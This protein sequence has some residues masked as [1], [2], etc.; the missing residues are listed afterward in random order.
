[1]SKLNNALLHLSGNGFTKV[2]IEQIKSSPTLA[3]MLETFTKN[4]NE[5][6]VFGDNG[7]HFNTK[8]GK[9]TIGKP[10]V[11]TLAH[12]LG[13]ALGKLQP[14]NLPEAKSAKE[15]LEIKLTA[16]GEAKCYE[17]I[18]M[19]EI[20]SNGN[21][22][23]I[24]PAEKAAGWF[25]DKL[26]I[27]Q[28]DVHKNIAD[29][30]KNVK[31][32]ND[33]TEE[34][35]K[36][37]GKEVKQGIFSGQT[38]DYQHIIPTF[39]YE[40]EY[41]LNF[42]LGQNKY[43]HANTTLRPDYKEVIGSEIFDSGF[44]IKSLTNGRNGQLGTAG[45]DV[46]TNGNAD[47]TVLAK[48]LENYADRNGDLWFGDKGNDTIQG[49]SGKDI[50]LGGED[51]DHLY[52]NGGNDILGGNAGDD[53]LYGGEGRN[54]LK[55]GVGND[56][57]HVSG[58]DTIFDKDF[59]GSIHFGDTDLATQSFKMIAP[60]L[61]KSEDG[62]FILNSLN[63]AN[64]DLLII[65]S[66]TNSSALVEGFFDKVTH[67]D[68]SYQ[69]L[70][71]T[72]ADKISDDAAIFL[73]AD[74]RYNDITVLSS[75][76]VQ[77]GSK[78]DFVEAEQSQMTAYLGRG[79][80]RAHGGR[81]AD[82]IAGQEGNDVIFGGGFADNDVK[83][84]D[85][86][87]GGSGRDIIYGLHGNDVI[88]ASDAENFANTQSI[89]KGGD[90]VGGGKGNDYL[91]GSNAKDVLM[92]GEG[93]DTI[94]GGAGSDVIVGDGDVRLAVEIGR[95]T[96]SGSSSIDVNHV[97]ADD[98]LKNFIQA[99][100]RD[101]VDAVIEYMEVDYTYPGRG[102]VAHFD[103]SGDDAIA[104]VPPKIKLTHYTHFN[105]QAAI[106]VTTGDYS[107]DAP[108]GKVGSHL[109]DNGADD[110]LYGGR[111]DDLIIGQSGNDYLEGGIGNDILWGDDNR[112]ASV[113]GND[114]LKGGEGN[115]TFYGG[116][117]GDI[118]E[119][120]AGEDTYVIYSKD[121]TSWGKSDTTPFDY[122]IIRDSNINKIII[123]DV[124]WSDK[125]W[126]TKNMAKTSWEE[127]GNTDNK[128]TLVNKQLFLSINDKIVAVVE[129]FDINAEE[130]MLLS[131]LAEGAAPQIAKPFATQ[132][133]VVKNDHWELEIPKNHFQD[134]DIYMYTLKVNGKDLKNY[135]NIRIKNN[136]S[137][138]NDD[139]IITGTGKFKGDYKM[140]LTAVDREQ[141]TTTGS[142][143]VKFQNPPESKDKFVDLNMK[144]GESIT[145]FLPPDNFSDI[146]GDALTYKAELVN[147]SKTEKLPDWV[148]VDFDN[149]LVNVDA[150]NDSPSEITIKITATE[151]NT[152][153]KLSESDSFTVTIEDVPANPTP[154]DPTPVDPPVKTQTSWHGGKVEGGSGDDSLGGSAFH[155]TLIGNGG[156]DTLSSGL[157]S[158]TLNG[159]EGN[160]ILN[161][162][163]GADMLIGGKG[164]DILNGGLGGDTYQF[165]IGDGQDIITDQGG[166]FDRLVL[167]DLTI[168]DLL[169]DTRGNDWVISVKNSDDKITIEDANHWMGGRIENFEVGG[170]NMS[171]R[172]FESAMTSHARLIS[173]EQP[174]ALI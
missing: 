50:I 125:V 140:E 72:F 157:G 17:Y 49:N 117:G 83:D 152:S 92:G 26:F 40:E 84:H 143:D 45:D 165:K 14:Q 10:S 111:G 8:S 63:N 156:D 104:S 99:G 28:F 67:A 107:I 158:D 33:I 4:T 98:E 59:T 39:T 27:E 163:W 6:I 94:Y 101:D 11:L 80:D 30:V 78:A 22:P 65:D 128:L 81:D 137:D 73:G 170:D 151:K 124:N 75:T 129:N 38:I 166:L 62:R 120:G 149:W 150:P 21:V 123:D 42:L 41:T 118:L 102:P 58:Q 168:D 90:F 109:V 79:N 9:I 105:W 127:E 43:H 70:G 148:K 20:N 130:K 56:T 159:G 91:F 61:W 112:D 60:N 100:D 153:Q 119:G 32:P 138:N 24:K 57:Y 3:N 35:C 55:G 1:M 113:S 126:K 64:K 53:H 66:E 71:L 131:K 44:H 103:I 5:V 171:Y 74:N 82:Y 86:L 89:D 173:D 162:G 19:E 167:P 46:L 136:H 16:E 121:V 122:D 115:D 37:I 25:D 13:H 48:A 134:K 164:N 142:F 106:N 169:L 12:E 76:I 114:Y 29:Y 141:H 85:T 97:T 135:P 69:G 36:A 68:G 93:T 160:D 161:A 154:V 87:I 145:K 77:T 96:A 146:D 51:N 155:D 147:G 172:E 88:Y 52:G 133:V 23:T 7:S 95:I 139:I 54:I 34:L 31:T 144:E 132:E 116:K 110:F 47:N 174:V 15:H 108:K 18:V 2:Q